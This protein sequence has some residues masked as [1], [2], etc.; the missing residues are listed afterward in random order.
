MENETKKKPGRLETVEAVDRFVHAGKAT[1]TLR[2]KASE[3]R[4]TYKVSAKKEAPTDPIRFVKVLTGSDNESA[5]QY[6][7]FL[8]RGGEF[9]HHRA[10]SR[11]GAE[12]PSVKAFSWFYGN[13]G[14]GRLPEALEVYHEGR[15]GACRRKLTV[16]ES[17]MTGFGPECSERL[18][19]ER[20]T[21][22]E[23]REAA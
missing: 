1:V 8:R 7:G 22:E 3:A 5:Y 19:I 16:P 13:L 14:R 4:F 9:V 21:C 2:S 18:G 11:I 6:L 12:A 15:C 17:V 23:V 10:K 20:V